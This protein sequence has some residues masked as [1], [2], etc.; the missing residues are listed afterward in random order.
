MSFQ[1]F[2][3]FWD[4]TEVTLGQECAVWW[5]D[6]GGDLHSSLW[7]LSQHMVGEPWALFMAPTVQCFLII[8]S[9]HFLYDLWMLFSVFQY[10]VVIQVVTCC[11]FY[12]RIQPNTEQFTCLHS[13]PQ[14]QRYWPMN[15]NWWNIFCSQT[16]H[17]VY[18]THYLILSFLWL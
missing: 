1:V 13:H 9:T 10:A 16:L 15:E 8:L 18:L 6:H 5:V 14:E 12:K 7:L 17:T 4:D 3:L 11:M 2:L